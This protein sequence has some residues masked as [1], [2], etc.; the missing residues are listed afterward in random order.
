M[1]FGRN[2]EARARSERAAALREVL[3]RDVPE[4]PRYRYELAETY[5]RSAQA[6]EAEGDLAGSLAD[7][8]RAAALFRSVPKLIGK[9][10]FFHGCTH[11]L[12][13][14]LAG[15]P[16]AGISAADMEAEAVQAIALLRQAAAVDSLAPCA[17][18]GETVL[19]SLRERAE[20]HLLMMDVAFPVDPFLGGAGAR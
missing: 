14:R 3:I 5:L 11:A 12:I 19:D 7:A 15:K 2:V 8:R 9:Y 16:E 4:V 1:S 6:R 13:A 17:F 18:R 20:Y 10:L